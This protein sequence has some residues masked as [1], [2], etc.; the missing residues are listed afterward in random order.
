MTPPDIASKWWTGDL[1]LASGTGNVVTVYGGITW[2]F[3]L[4][5]LPE[6]TTG[7][8]GGYEDDGMNVDRFSPT[9]G[10]VPEPRGLVLLA[11]GV[12]LLAL[13]R[14]RWLTLALASPA[15]AL[16]AGPGGA[17]DRTGLSVEA[18]RALD[19]MDATPSPRPEGWELE[20]ILDRKV[21]AKGG[22]IPFALEYR[23]RSRVE[24][25]I[26]RTDFGEYHWLEVEPRDGHSPAPKP[27][28]E[29]ELSRKRFHS[30]NIDHRWWSTV[31][32]GG[33]RRV[34]LP[35]LTYFYGF[36]PGDYRVR[37]TYYED[38]PNGLYKLVSGWVRFRVEKP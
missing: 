35:D 21:S 31:G 33:R 11:T 17:D 32:P 25:R 10:V 37:V 8:L 13:T 1:L 38:G 36:E 28:D 15:A 24:G 22:S 29:G 12:G 27:T 5:T 30:G 6:G 19:R 18:T 7:A 16:A 4:F 3:Q 26:C 2:G 23:N 9:I 14:R 34:E 20:V